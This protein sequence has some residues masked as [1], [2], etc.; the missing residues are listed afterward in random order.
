MLGSTRRVLGCTPLWVQ[1]YPRVPCMD[2]LPT[3]PLPMDV[4]LSGGLRGRTTLTDHSHFPASSGCKAHQ[5]FE[6]IRIRLLHIP[7]KPRFVRL[8]VCQGSNVDPPIL[9]LLCV[10]RV[11]G[12]STK[13]GVS[14]LSPSCGGQPPFGGD[15]C[16]CENSVHTRRVHR[17][18]QPIAFAWN[19]KTVLKPVHAKQSH[20]HVVGLCC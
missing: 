6:L 3:F 4:L 14:D 15:V 7:N 9:E 8:S 18:T 12:D 13:C 17:V 11:D 2:K 5:L 16:D 1:Q 20:S 19:L 10:A